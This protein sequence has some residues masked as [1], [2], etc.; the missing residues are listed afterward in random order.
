MHLSIYRFVVLCTSV[1]LGLGPGGPA[2]AGGPRVTCRACVLVDEEGRTIW[3]RDENLPLPNA[4]TTKMATAILTLSRVEA[5]AAVTVSAGAASTGVGGFDLAAGDRYSV[6]ELLHALLLSSSND[7]AVALAEYVAGSEAA[8]VKR[9]NLTVDRLGAKHTHFVTAHG[10]DE[11]GHHASASDLARIGDALLKRPLL[12]RI[13]G[14]SVTT[15][16]RFGGRRV[17]NTNPLID[18]YPGA[19]GVKTGYTAAAGEVLVAA[20]ERK[21]RR[22]MAVAMGS[23]DAAADARRLLDHGFRQLAETVLLDASNPAGALV[24]D[25]AGAIAATAAHAVTGSARPS[26]VK[27]ALSPSARVSPPFHSG[28]QVGIFVVTASD[29]H[30]ATVPAIAGSGLSTGGRGARAGWTAGALAGVLGAA[31]RMLG[32][33]GG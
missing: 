21:G 14:T 19:V 28:E 2:Q 27:I 12:A 25:P 17:E 20:A 22:L 23:D 4:S 10:L 16:G 15:V 1:F 9:L 24:F 5:H 18:T 7:A 33:T 8:F 6:A 13:V 11:P 26:D 32:F 30:V 29:R 3:G 31:A